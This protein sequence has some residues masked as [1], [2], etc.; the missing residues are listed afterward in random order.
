MKD[1]RLFIT[2]SFRNVKDYNEITYHLL[3][4]F[5]SFSQRTEGYKQHPE[6]IE[7][8]EKEK[9]ELEVNLCYQRLKMP[10]QENQKIWF[11]KSTIVFCA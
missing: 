11:T 7:R 8:E 9:R 3:N 10:Y 2:H 6:D 5:L 4:C 1:K